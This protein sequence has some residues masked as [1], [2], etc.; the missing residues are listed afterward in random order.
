MRKVDPKKLGWCYYESGVRELKRCYEKIARKF[1][2]DLV[3]SLIKKPTYSTI[4]AEDLSQ[5]PNSDS[6]LESKIHA[7]GLPL[8]EGESAPKKDTVIN[9]ELKVMSEKPEEGTSE[10]KAPEIVEDNKLQTVQPIQN[11]P[12]KEDSNTIIEARSSTRLKF[13]HEDKEIEE[14]L[15]DYLGL[16][17]FDEVYERISRKSYIGKRLPYL[18]VALNYTT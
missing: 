15:R 14:K 12:N 18:L 1:A 17:I 13:V 3:D 6:W 5:N 9:L 2:H 8:A 16:P 7:W 11:E 4:P 10:Q